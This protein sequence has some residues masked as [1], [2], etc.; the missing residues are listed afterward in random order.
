[1]EYNSMLVF[2]K[3]TQLTGFQHHCEKLKEGRSWYGKKPNDGSKP[4]PRFPR[5]LEPERDQYRRKYPDNGFDLSGNGN[6]N[7]ITIL[8]PGFH[9]L[10][11]A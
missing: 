8:L 10:Q 5:Y 3:R 1:M 6:E 4:T 7:N 11:K 9:H 2:I